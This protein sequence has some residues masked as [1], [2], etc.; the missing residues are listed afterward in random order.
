MTTLAGFLVRPRERRLTMSLEL[1][2]IGLVVA[3]CAL[4]L[5]LTWG[6]WGDVNGDT[7]YDVVA[8]ARVAHGQFPYVDY[9]YY[10]GPLGPLLLGAVFALTGPGVGPALALGLVLGVA[11][12]GC[13]YWLAREFVGPVG[14]AGAALLAAPLVFAPNY[15]SFVYPYTYATTLGV[16]GLLVL[17]VALT[18]R[19]AA[20]SVV[21]GVTAGCVALTKP[22]FASAAAVAIAVWLAA[23]PAK[24]RGRAALRTLLPAVL[25]PAF[26]YGAFAARV[27]LHRLLFVNLDPRAELQAAVN[28]TLR[29]RMPWTL[30]SFENLAGRAAVYVLGA[31]ALLLVAR[32]LRPR[33]RSRPV[34][35]VA[36]PVAA[37]LALVGLTDIGKLR[38]ILE[39]AYGGLP[40]IALAGAVA[41]YIRGRRRRW[42]GEARS[43]AVVVAALAVLSFACYGGFY[44]YGFYPQTAVFAAPLVAVFLTRVHLVDL[45]RMPIAHALGAAWLMF[46]IIAGSALTAHDAAAKSARI[47]GPGGSLRATPAI[48]G[49]YQSA[50][51][52]IRSSSQ[53]GQAILIAPA[54]TSLYTLADRSSPLDRISLLPGALPNDGEQR[55]VIAALQR[56]RVQV[57]LTDRRRWTEYGQTS[58]GESFDRTLAAWIHK[59]FRLVRTLR[60]TGPNPIVLDAWRRTP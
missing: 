58:F 25:I 31:V 11:I 9:V 13:T 3:G 35:A 15:Y 16:L 43:L 42:S 60:G 12:V 26:V 44:L 1:A 22:E 41:F 56:A 5:G 10:Y 45:A 37:G 24:A 33:V 20:W 40:A 34:L 32:L 51:D 47:V 57:I 36:L 29:S 54:D 14:S 50:L 6:R 39:L 28:V 21:A 30:G 19:P 48:A 38:H 2:G 46:L 59:N 49:A 7:G 27:G 53:A 52:W 18:R 8:A 17:L 55:K 4:L 23:T